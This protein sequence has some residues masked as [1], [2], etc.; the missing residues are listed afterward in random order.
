MCA[1]ALIVIAG[2]YWQLDQ[3]EPFAQRR[4][5]IA[6][7]AIAAATLAIGALPHLTRPVLA[8]SLLLVMSSAELWVVAD[9]SPARQAPP[10]VFSQGETVDWLRAHGVT[11]Q[12]RLLSLARPEYVP[13]AEDQVRAELGTLPETIVDAA[14]VAQKWHDTLSPNLP[15]QFGLNTADG[16]DGGVL[17]LARWLRLSTLLVSS[18]RSDGVLLTRLESL[19]TDRLLDLFGVRY[20]IANAETPGRADMLTVDFGDLLLFVRP[21]AVPR[22]LVVF[23]VTAAGDDTAVLDRMA[24]AD[25]DSKREVVLGAPAPPGFS[26]EPLPVQPDQVGPQ[27][28]RARV[29]LTQPGYLLQREAWYPGW[30]ARVDGVDTPVVRADLLFR[31][32]ALDPGEHDVEIFF[33]SSSFTR[34]VLLSAAGLVAVILLLSWRP[35]MRMRAKA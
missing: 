1:V 19:P 30:R 24:Q 6:F 11:D 20:L 23:G 35:I 28:W 12:D 34:G 3:G 5:P 14:L 18:P 32:V 29:S 2:V 26:A 7:A 17:P 31:A 4:T 33:D 10:P 9:A 21:N 13:T 15:L 8:M 25:F 22:S 16:Y 27:Q